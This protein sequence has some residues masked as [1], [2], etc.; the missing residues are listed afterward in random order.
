[1][2]KLMKANQAD[3]DQS[4]ASEKDFISSLITDD[5]R[6]RAL[7]WFIIENALMVLLSQASCYLRHPGVEERQKSFLKRELGSELGTFLHGVHRFKTR[8]GIPPSPI[9]SEKHGST[10]SAGP[11]LSMRRSPSKLSTSFSEDDENS[12]LFRFV[13]TFAK[14]LLR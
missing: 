7:L 6:K 5:E 14:T 8:R 12:S 1:M 10:T 11:S 4:S 13:D 3:P 2:G 9:S